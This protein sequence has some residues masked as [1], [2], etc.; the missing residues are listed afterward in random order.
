MPAIKYSNIAE[1]IVEL[2]TTS[3]DTVGLQVYNGVIGSDDMLQA[4]A[5]LEFVRRTPHSNQVI[6]GGTRMRY[7]LEYVMAVLCGSLE[8]GRAEVMRD[9]Y[10]SVIE[11]ILMSNRKLDGLVTTLLLDG[12]EMAAGYEPQSGYYIAGG[13]VKF[14]VDAEISI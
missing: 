1:K 7:N 9:T 5:T 6:A 2:V 10:I 14:F 11:T 3:P 8:Q 12:G 13:E 4:Q